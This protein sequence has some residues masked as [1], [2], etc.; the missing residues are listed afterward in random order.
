MEHRCG[1]SSIYVPSMRLRLREPAAETS[2]NLRALRERH[3]PALSYFDLK[4][5][6]GSP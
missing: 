1:C 5:P 4:N 3:S 6:G 2:H